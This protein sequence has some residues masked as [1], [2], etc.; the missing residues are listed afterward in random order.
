MRARGEGKRG[1]AHPQALT[2]TNTLQ[3]KNAGKKVGIE[4]WRIEQFKVVPWPKR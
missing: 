1:D 2:R 4:V 3:W